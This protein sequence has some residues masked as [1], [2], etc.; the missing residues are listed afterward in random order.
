MKKVILNLTAIFLVSVFSVSFLSCGDDE[1]KSEVFQL[2]EETKPFIGYW[3]YI[4][5][6]KEIWYMMSLTERGIYQISSKHGT[7]NGEMN[8]GTFSYDGATK[9]LRFTPGSALNMSP[10]SYSVLNMT[11]S[12]LLVNTPDGQI[13][14]EKVDQWT[15]PDSYHWGNPWYIGTWR[16]DIYDELSTAWDDLYDIYTFRKDGTAVYAYNHWGTP[17]SFNFVSYGV[18]PDYITL[19]Y[20]DGSNRI[21]ELKSHTDDS[22]TIEKNDELQIFIKQ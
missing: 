13:E 8:G 22:F 4:S 21:L 11:G 14:Y 2:T 10:F 9:Q 1:G 7:S 18:S 19:T 6:E 20:E 5:H 17:Y 12:K 16:H 15:L 3:H